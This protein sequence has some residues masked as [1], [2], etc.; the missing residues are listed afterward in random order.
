MNRQAKTNIM[1]DKQLTP[2]QELIEWIIKYEKI[3][4]VFPN[5]QECMFQAELLKEKEETLIV[6]SW[7]DGKENKTFGDNVLTMH[8]TTTK[9][10]LKTIRL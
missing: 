6:C 1:T 5:G 10:N 9:T 4:K 3:N 7:I 8:K 2:M